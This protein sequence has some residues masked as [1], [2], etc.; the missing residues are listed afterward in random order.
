ANVSLSDTIPANTTFVSMSPLNGWII[1]SPGVGNTG[2][3][4][5]TNTSL[6]PS[7]PAIFTLIVKVDGSTPN[8]ADIVNTANVF[9]TTSQGHDTGANSATTH[10]T[11]QAQLDFGD[12]PAS[13]GTLIADDGARHVISNGLHMGSSVDFEINGQ[14]NA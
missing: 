5:A 10:T 7:P 9:T 11:A 6:A 13:Y 2:T 14:P 4:T 3:V 12:A 8:G 1:S